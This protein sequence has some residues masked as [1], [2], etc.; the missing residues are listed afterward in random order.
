VLAA[1]AGESI[2]CF[3]AFQGIIGKQQWLLTGDKTAEDKGEQ[4]QTK[5]TAS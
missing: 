2:V 1:A 4:Q 3:F 5:R